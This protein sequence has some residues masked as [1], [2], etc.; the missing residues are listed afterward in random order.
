MSNQL[1]HVRL[2]FDWVAAEWIYLACAKRRT[3]WRHASRI[4]AGMIRCVSLQLL[5]DS[6]VSLSL[7]DTLHDMASNNFPRLEALTFIESAH[8]DELKLEIGIIV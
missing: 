3:E 5:L 4:W 6:K 2:H 8:I 7:S 1:V